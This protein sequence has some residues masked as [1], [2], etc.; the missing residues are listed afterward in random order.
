MGAA[1]VPAEEYQKE[2]VRLVLAM[3]LVPITA[4]YQ[5]HHPVV[6]LVIVLSAEIPTA[7][8]LVVFTTIV[9]IHATKVAAEVLSAIVVAVAAVLLVQVVLAAVLSAVA[10]EAVLAA[11]AEVLVLLVVDNQIDSVFYRIQL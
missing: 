10:E 5:A 3:A 4:M 8:C 7:V 1:L 2:S 9:L 6:V 11:V